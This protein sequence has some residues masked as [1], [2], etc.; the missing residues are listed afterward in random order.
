M[1]LNVLERTREIGVMRAVGASNMSIFTIVIAEGVV[2]GVI[3]VI[4]GALLAI[5]LSLA[6]CN[7]LGLAVLNSPLDFNYSLPA[8]GIWLAAA[9]IIATGASLFPA[10]SAVIYQRP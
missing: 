4:F 1:S 10:A 9:L 6:M 2:I 3:S 7:M 5:P 8:V